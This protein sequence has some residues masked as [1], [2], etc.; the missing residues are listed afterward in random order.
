MEQKQNK[1]TSKTDVHQTIPQGL[2]TNEQEEYQSKLKT[3]P[4]DFDF[5]HYKFN[6]KTLKRRSIMFIHRI[7]SN[8][9]LRGY[10]KVFH[11]VKVIG[12]A[13]V[14]ELKKKGVVVVSNHIHPLDIQMIMTFLF[15]M[16]PVH[17][18]TLSRNFDLKSV[19]F[20]LK[21]SGAVPIPED[22]ENRIKCFEEM[23][24]LLK[25]NGVLHICPEGSLVH[26]CG[27]IRDF[28]EG[29][30]RFAYQNKVPILPV[31][32]RFVEYNAKGKKYKHP[33]FIIDISE[34]IYPDVPQDIMMQKTIRVMKNKCNGAVTPL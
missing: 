34:P 33:H 7:V 19:R 8:V 2:V 23:N 4:Y 15:G 26:M 1:V 32:L 12:K 16:R 29:A 6:D 31:T 13:N 21:N 25:E 27:E 17:F 24:T 5:E 3:K 11:K 22:R 9:F 20:M 18:L 10:L 30:F 14:L 28:K